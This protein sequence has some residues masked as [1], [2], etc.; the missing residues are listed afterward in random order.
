MKNTYSDS[1]SDFYLAHL[2]STWIFFFCNHQVDGLIFDLELPFLLWPIWKLVIMKTMRYFYLDKL[3]F[4]S[5]KSFCMLMSWLFFVNLTKLE[6]FKKR[7]SQLRKCFIRFAFWLDCPAFSG[8]LTDKRRSSPLGRWVPVKVRSSEQTIGSKSVRSSHSLCFLLHPDSC[9]AW[10][11]DPMSLDNGPLPRSIRWNK[12]YPPQVSLV[13]DVYHRNNYE[14]WGNENKFRLSFM[15]VLTYLPQRIK[16][17][18]LN[19]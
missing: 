17:V 16:N 19:L 15:I 1:L 18:C 4:I 13:M 2:Q 11:L 7:D 14:I 8:I 9:P 6:L 12:P 3:C 10:V 5:I